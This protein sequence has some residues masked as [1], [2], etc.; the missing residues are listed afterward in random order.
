M[1]L[2][3]FAPTKAYSDDPSQF[4]VLHVTDGPHREWF[5][6][7]GHL[8]SCSPVVLDTATDAPII[9]ALDECEGFTRV[10]AAEK[11]R[12]LPA[13]L[14]EMSLEQLRATREGTAVEGS[15]D[16]SRSKLRAE[17]AKTRKEQHDADEAEIE[18]AV[19]TGGGASEGD[20]HSE[21]V[22]PSPSTNPDLKRNVELGG[23]ATGES[24][25]DHE[26]GP[27]VETIKG[28]E[29]K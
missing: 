19:E 14:D 3:A 16:M 10:D 18:Y 2:V 29:D 20:T 21:P 25:D 26:D 11:T 8:A 23:A 6:D 27:T 1:T 17:M 9:K 15:E 22:G 7:T 28:G 5:V 4:E 13:T 24:T 12:T